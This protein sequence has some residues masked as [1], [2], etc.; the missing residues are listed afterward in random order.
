MLVAYDGIDLQPYSY[1]VIQ[2]AK[3]REKP[4]RLYNIKAPKQ[5]KRYFGYGPPQPRTKAMRSQ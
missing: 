1:S 2:N 4:Q 3:Y 5:R